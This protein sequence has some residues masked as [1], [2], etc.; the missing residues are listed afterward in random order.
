MGF[1][2]QVA[3]AVSILVQ[4]PVLKSIGDQFQLLP[5]RSGYFLDDFVKNFL[6]PKP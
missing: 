5:W 3:T 2:R 1:S 4:D 6:I